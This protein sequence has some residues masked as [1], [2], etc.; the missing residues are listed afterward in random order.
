[1]TEKLS[2][3]LRSKEIDKCIDKLRDLI[4][5]R[6]KLEEEKRFIDKNLNITLKELKKQ[7]DILIK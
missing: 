5:S 4:I 3:I 7:E 1:M 6:N 2:F